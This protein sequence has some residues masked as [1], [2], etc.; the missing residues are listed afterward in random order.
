MPDQPRRVVVKFGGADLATSENV[1][2]AAEMIKESGFSEIAIVVSAMG[3]TTDQLIGYTLEIGKIDDYDYS[4]IVA[5]GE[6]ISARVFSSTLKSIGVESTYF[7]P[8]QARWP[9]ITDS[10]FR[11]AKPLFSETR[12]KVKKHIEP[13]LGTCVPVI[14]GFLGRDLEGRITLLSRGGSDITAT[15][16]GKCLEADEVILVKET[17]GVL[18]ADPHEIPDAQLLSKLT[19]EEMFSMAHGGAKVIHPE[20]LKYKLPTQKLRFV[21][22]AQGRFSETGTEIMG[23]FKSNSMET[24][25]QRGLTAF[26]LIGVINSNNLSELFSTL[27]NS[28]ILGISTGG[29]SVTVFAQ[30]HDSKRITRKLHA[31]ECFKAVSSRGYVGVVKMLNPEFIDS[32]GW[33]AKISGS[34][35]DKDI[36]ILEMTTSKASISVFVDERRLDEALLV[37]RAL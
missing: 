2:K 12:E 28:E 16:L 11:N 19:V 29:S 34:L 26:T 37:L 35:A 8:Q 9:V 27:G 24:T 17:E 5:M 25:S 3:K 1:K 15:L 30:V 21:S 36:N 32:P 20:A 33:I 22:L 23:E 4:E 10:N 18:S 7:D 31:L 14:C 13:L 6:R